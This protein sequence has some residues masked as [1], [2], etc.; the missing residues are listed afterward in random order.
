MD[1]SYDFIVYLAFSFLFFFFLAFSY[2]YCE[3]VFSTLLCLMWNLGIPD[4]C[5]LFA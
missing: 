3:S 1:S 2:C 4:V 5:V